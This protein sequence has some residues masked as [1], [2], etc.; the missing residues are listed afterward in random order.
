[1]DLDV[2]NLPGVVTDPEADVEVE[3][4]EE[5]ENDPEL[6]AE[7]RKVH[8]E[9]VGEHHADEEPRSGAA[10]PVQRKP[11]PVSQAP[12]PLLDLEVVSFEDKMASTDPRELA[13]YINEEKNKVGF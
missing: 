1:M 12:S 6:L 5:D 8:P 13:Q 2:D 11:V 10:L 4:N 7:L 9:A 3:F